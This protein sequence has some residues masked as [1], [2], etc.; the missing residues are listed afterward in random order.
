MQVFHTYL[1]RACGYVQLDT[2][3]AYY[4]GR[5]G[6]SLE[7]A[8]Q[9]YVVYAIDKWREERPTFRYHLVEC[10]TDPGFQLLD[11]RVF[12]VPAREMKRLRK[13]LV[14]F[15]NA[16]WGDCTG[17]GEHGESDVLLA[18]GHKVVATWHCREGGDRK[19]TRLNS[20]HGGISRMPSSA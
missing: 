13:Q 8:K 1:L 14:A 2:A 4:S 3:C 17:T 19:S 18:S 5:L 7:W 6:Y 16:E 10:N 20:S 9:R 12:E 15:S 11:S